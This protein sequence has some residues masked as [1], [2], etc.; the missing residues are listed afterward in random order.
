MLIETLLLV[1]QHYCF[2]RLKL[3]I[4][5]KLAQSAYFPKSDKIGV[6]NEMLNFKI[7]E[8]MKTNE[9]EG[10]L[11]VMELMAVKGGIDG[12]DVVCKA[13]DSGVICTSGAVAI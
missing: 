2:C 7:I 11:D 3:Y 6:V 9:I 12:I 8:I 1:R 13:Q 5:T 4:Q 10:K